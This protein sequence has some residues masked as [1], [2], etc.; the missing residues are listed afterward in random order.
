MNPRHHRKEAGDS[1]PSKAVFGAVYVCALAVCA[2]LATMALLVT[3]YPVFG[4][5]LM[6]VIALGSGSAP[7]F[8]RQFLA[9]LVVS[10]L[11]VAG[12]LRLPPVLAAVKTRT[13]VICSLIISLAIQLAWLLLIMPG[14][15]NSFYDTQSL[16]RIA[17]SFLAGDYSV[18]QNADDLYSNPP[19][20]IAIS[21]STYLNLVPYQAGSVFVFSLLRSLFGTAFVPAFQVVNA[22]SGTG[23]IAL[24]LYSVHVTAPEDDNRVKLTAVLLACFLPFLFSCSFVY[25]N[26]IGLCFAT[27][28]VALA[29]RAFALRNADKRLEIALMMTASFACTII[30]IILKPTL[31]LLA[32]G[33]IAVWVIFLIRERN[34]PLL[35]ILIVL[36]LV[37]SQASTFAT[38][39]LEH[40]VGVE[41]GDGFT[42]TTYIAM[43]TSWSEDNDLPGWYHHMEQYVYDAGGNPDN[44]NALAI[45]AIKEN[46]DAFAHDAGYAVSFFGE[47][48]ATEWAD[49]SYQS[50][51][52]SRFSIP[53]GQRPP[54]LY[55][56]SQKSP[57]NA[58]VTVVLD[59]L[60]T[61]LYAF[62]ALGLLG[63][64]RDTARKRF[65]YLNLL[66]ATLFLCGF[67][68]YLLWEAQSMYALP[69]A[70]LLIP[71]AASGT[72]KARTFIRNRRDL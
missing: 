59:G 17:D 28:G 67:G 13:V 53:D 19:Q 43:G 33:E 48:L 39:A 31:I 8:L 7:D 64:I 2:F 42:K 10:I 27:G 65:D 61:L 55:V 46:F 60:Q 62:A 58:A 5:P 1:T 29:A 50:F 35:P 72:L 3:C 30:A 32:I 51:W 21:E 14:D 9:P 52:F 23:T 38:A 71:L 24:I 44:Q 18:F 22:L 70:L 4:T 15:F 25:T 34:L 54:A 6:N 36:A 41:F 56:I 20:E 12:I 16:T 68:C 47:K 45:E 37:A 49:P 63:S 26:A 11:V 66:L 57:L 40:M 69:F